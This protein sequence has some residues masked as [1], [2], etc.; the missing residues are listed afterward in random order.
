MFFQP[1]SCLRGCPLLLLGS[2]LKRPSWGMNIGEGNVYL[3]DQSVLR[4]FMIC[5]HMLDLAWRIRH[6]PN[7]W[8]LWDRGRPG[9]LNNQSWKQLFRLFYL[10]TNFS[11]NMGVSLFSL[12]YFR[13]LL[14]LLAQRKIGAPSALFC[15]CQNKNGV[16]C[17]LLTKFSVA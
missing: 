7:A 5:I 15:I 10:W 12:F 2:G 4:G 11:F 6:N 8:G 13:F 16:Q 9:T 14:S 17:V 1:S 3:C